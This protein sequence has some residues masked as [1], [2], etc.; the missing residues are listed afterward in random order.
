MLN[1]D[2]TGIIGLLAIGQ[3]SALMLYLGGQIRT[4]YALVLLLILLMIL[5]TALTHDILLHTKLALYFPQIIGLGPVHTYLVG[6][7]ALMISYK[8]LHPSQSLSKLHGLHFVP[9]VV[10][11]WSQLPTLLLSSDEKL[12]IIQRYFQNPP[13]LLS[14]DL[15]FENIGQ[16]IVF[17]GHRFAY[18]AVI[19]YLFSVK[20][21]KLKYA[22]QSRTRF[23][24][25]LKNSLLGYCIIWGSARILIFIPTIG[26]LILGASNIINAIG[27]SLMVILVA[28]FCFN[29]PIREV[30]SPKSTQK[31]QNANIGDDLNSAI[32]QEIS[33]QLSQKKVFSNPEVKVSDISMLSGFSNHQISQAINQSDYSTFNSLLNHYR[34]KEF[35]KLLVEEKNSETELLQLAFSAGFNSKATFNRVFK[36]QTGLTPRQYRASR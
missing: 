20:Q 21:A 23:S 5:S 25:L 36:Q 33:Q 3:A 19:I 16:F 30:F 32:F 31:Y 35:K 6:P 9:F 13:E 34:I 18:F 27:L 28:N 24:S 26:E 14:P 15:N 7:I 10:H 17:Y 4:N 2:W 29:F 11:L 12:G 1:F 8:L 22:V